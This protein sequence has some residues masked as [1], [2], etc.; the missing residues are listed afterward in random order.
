MTT[1]YYIEDDENIARLV[2]EYL[3]R[4]G[5]SVSIFPTIAGA[6][7]A[8]QES[9]PHWRWWTGICRTVPAAL[10]VGGSAPIGKICR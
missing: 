9:S 1:I 4:Q 2:S 5:Y 10:S 3:N 8:L 7:E 6:R